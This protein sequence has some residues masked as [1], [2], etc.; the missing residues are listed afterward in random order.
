ME[1]RIKLEESDGGCTL[2]PAVEGLGRNDGREGEGTVPGA[3]GRKH[4][5]LYE[6]DLF[7][8]IARPGCTGE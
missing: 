8:I 7:I 4:G 3:D 6:Q 2:F 5:I 1:R